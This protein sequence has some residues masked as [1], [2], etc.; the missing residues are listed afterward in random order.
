MTP[1][2]PSPSGVMDNS[3]YNLYLQQSANAVYNHPSPYGMQQP[4]QAYPSI[5]PGVLDNTSPTP[6][7]G[8]WPPST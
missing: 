1:Y 6:P 2:M 8:Y 5:P 7:E 4:T 3:R